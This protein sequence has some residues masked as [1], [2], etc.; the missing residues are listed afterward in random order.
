VR[1]ADAAEVLA[2]PALREVCQLGCTLMAGCEQI[3]ADVGIPSGVG[4]AN[5]VVLLAGTPS[6][7]ADVDLDGALA[8]VAAGCGRSEHGFTDADCGTTSGGASIDTRPAVHTTAS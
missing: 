5:G 4:L 7:P 2:V 6:F 1:A 3:P 8:L